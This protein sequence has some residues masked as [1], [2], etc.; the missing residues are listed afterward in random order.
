MI[1]G[2]Y[3]QKYQSK[4]IAKPGCFY[5]IWTPSFILDFRVRA[6]LAQAVIKIVRF[7]GLARDLLAVLDDSFG[8]LSVARKN[9]EKRLATFQS[10]INKSVEHLRL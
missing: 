10:E 5:F 2:I 9:V 6:D 7:S 3:L 8:V 4:N 1:A